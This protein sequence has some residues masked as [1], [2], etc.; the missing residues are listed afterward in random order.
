MRYLL[1]VIAVILLTACGE[2]QEVEDNT[3]TAS[4]TEQVEQEARETIRS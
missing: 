1:A 3:D 2:S 4:S